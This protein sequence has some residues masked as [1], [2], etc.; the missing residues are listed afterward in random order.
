MK[1]AHDWNVFSADRA[2][3][4]VSEVPLSDVKAITFYDGCVTVGAISVFARVPGDVA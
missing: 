4:I 2:I 3:H 1:F